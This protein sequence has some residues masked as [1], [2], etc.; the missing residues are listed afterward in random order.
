MSGSHSVLD[1][2]AARDA[3]AA[4]REGSAPS[5]RWMSLTSE[6]EVLSTDASEAL[7]ASVSLFKRLPADHISELARQ[8]ERR[9]VPAGQV[10]GALPHTFRCPCG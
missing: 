5:T 1:A 4:A 8:L 6:S 7:L 2:V 9:D 3:A 10:I